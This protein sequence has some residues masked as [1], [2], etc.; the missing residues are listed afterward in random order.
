MRNVKLTIQYDGTRYKGW[1]RLGNSQMTIQGKIEDVL[2]KMTGE[3]IEIFGSGRTDAGVHALN[4]SANFKTNCQMTAREILDYC[5]RYLPEDIVVKKVEK[6]DDKFHARYNVKSKR[7]LYRIYN[8]KYHDP[9]MRK[10]I[11]HIP[12]KLNIADMKTAAGYL[13]GEHDF[14]SFTAAKSKK[15]SRVRKIYDIN[16][17]KEDNIIEIMIHGNGFLHNMVRIIVGTLIEVGSGRMEG[18]EVLKVLNKKDRRLAGPTAPSKG[19]F[20]YNVEY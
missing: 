20:L 13:I 11:T 4:Q 8:Y 15:K 3:K 16:I 1:Q 14:S 6:V 17:S 10:Y 19:L 2:S 12:E 18:E 9:F 5:Y 7:Y